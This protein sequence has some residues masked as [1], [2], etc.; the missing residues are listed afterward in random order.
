MQ[1]SA[2]SQLEDGKEI[3]LALLV[4]GSRMGAR[5]LRITHYPPKPKSLDIV[6]R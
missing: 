2:E 1:L 6:Y 3:V 4:S 5:Y